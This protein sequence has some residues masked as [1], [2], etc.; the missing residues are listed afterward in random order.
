MIRTATCAAC[1]ATFHE[2]CDEFLES[3][4]CQECEDEI[5][6]FCDNDPQLLTSGLKY[7]G[8]YSENDDY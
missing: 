4:F 1:H 6:Q 2:E 5:E 8:N 7:I 3:E